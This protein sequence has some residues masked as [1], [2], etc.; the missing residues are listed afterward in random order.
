MN[1]SVNVQ[2][3]P[4]GSYHGTLTLSSGPEGQRCR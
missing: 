2:G 4:P 3:L 1:A